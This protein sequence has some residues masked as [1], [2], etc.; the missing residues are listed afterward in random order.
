MVGN[1]CVV[2]GKALVS[3][4]YILG[5]HNLILLVLLMAARP[6]KKAWELGIRSSMF[7]RL[8]GGAFCRNHA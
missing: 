7:V 1:K 5:G 3:Q 6:A 4:R 2:M 8:L